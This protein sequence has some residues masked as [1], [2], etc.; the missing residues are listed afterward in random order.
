MTAV[1]WPGSE[2]LQKNLNWHSPS[3]CAALV[4]QEFCNDFTVW[5]SEVSILLVWMVNQVAP[6][7]DKNHAPVL[8]SGRHSCCAVG[9]IHH[10]EKQHRFTS[11]I[12]LK[13]VTGT[14]FRL[15]S[16][17]MMDVMLALPSNRDGQLI[18]S[19][20]PLPRFGRATWVCTHG[21]VTKLPIW[22]KCEA[23]PVDGSFS[24]DEQ[25]RSHFEHRSSTCLSSK[26]WQVRMY[27]QDK[28]GLGYTL[29]KELLLQNC[30]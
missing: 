11:L 24:R 20:L 17:R 10:P 9:L 22:A 5:N 13:T 7:R 19:I 12:E 30:Q 4:F 15:S 25:D 8:Y 21:N 1:R 26:W 18:W 16:P 27:F 23:I 29:Q 3:F 6:L 2:T 14:S 28:C